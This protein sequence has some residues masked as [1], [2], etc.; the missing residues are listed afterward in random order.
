MA[1]KPL[2]SDEEMPAAAEVPAASAPDKEPA[3]IRVIGDKPAAPPREDGE[4]GE[5]DEELELELDD[6]EDED[7]VVYTAQEAAGALTSIYAFVKP[8]LRNYKKLLVFVG[9]GIVIE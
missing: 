9:L 8:Y 6:D 7:L 3:A 2:P 4:T 5:H 1:P